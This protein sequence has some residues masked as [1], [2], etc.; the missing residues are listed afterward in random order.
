MYNVRTNDTN[1]II[2]KTV[3]QLVSL[4]TGIVQR[5]PCDTQKKSRRYGFQGT[6]DIS[7]TLSSSFS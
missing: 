6:D 3:K 5:I 7:V 4:T 2:L 1:Y